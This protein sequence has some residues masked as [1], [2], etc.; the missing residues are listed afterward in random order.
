VPKEKHNGLRRLS[1]L[2]YRLCDFG[3]VAANNNRNLRIVALSTNRIT[4][5]GPMR[6]NAV[7]SCT[8]IRP[9]KR[10]INPA[11]LLKSYFTVEEFEG[12]IVEST[13]VQDDVSSRCHRRTIC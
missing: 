10:L 4:T 11:T 5:A 1:L 2:R 8:L 3:A 6:V 13:V 12:N 9:G 7:A